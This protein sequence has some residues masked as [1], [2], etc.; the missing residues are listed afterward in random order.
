MASSL[1][2]AGLIE[3][4][5]LFKLFCQISHADTKVTPGSYELKST[6]DYRAL[7]QNMKPGSGSAVTVKVTIPEG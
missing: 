4:E 1:K 5:W 3:Y 2:E 7:V 6:F